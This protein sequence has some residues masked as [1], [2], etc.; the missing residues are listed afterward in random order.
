MGGEPITR[1]GF[2]CPCRL[3]HT[4]AD[5]RLLLSGQ[6]IAPGETKRAG[7]RFS[8]E[9][10]P[11]AASFRQQRSS[12]YGTGALSAKASSRQVNDLPR[13]VVRLTGI[14]RAVAVG[15]DGRVSSPCGG[16]Y[17]PS[18]CSS[19]IFRSTVSASA[20]RR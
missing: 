8:F 5:C 7:I 20:I 4:S 10:E 16:A 13:Y 18:V 15:E 19:S 17:R 11:A 2:A 6:Q 3:N 9:P 12:T 1:E 14:E